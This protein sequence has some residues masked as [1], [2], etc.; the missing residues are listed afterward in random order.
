MRYKLSE[1][2]TSGE[3]EKGYVSVH[4][5]LA[6]I[7][8]DGSCFPLCQNLHGKSSK[9]SSHI[10]KAQSPDSGHGRPQYVLTLT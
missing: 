9:F 5:E 8:A 2:E 4:V 1:D 7:Q 3:S 10:L 6:I